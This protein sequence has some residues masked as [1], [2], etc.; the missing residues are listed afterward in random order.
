MS[1]PLIKLHDN[2]LEHIVSYYFLQTKPIPSYA[3]IIVVGFLRKARI[4]PRSCVF[5]ENKY[6]QKSIKTFADIDRMLLMYLEILFKFYFSII[7]L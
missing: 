6:F 5:A 1:A 2:P 4:G 7:N 3:V